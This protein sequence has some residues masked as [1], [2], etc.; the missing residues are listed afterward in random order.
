MAL[1]E[2]GSQVT[3]L[4]SIK[5]CFLF[6][7][8]HQCTFFQG[9]GECP[10]NFSSK[11]KMS[12]LQFPHYQSDNGILIRQLDRHSH[13]FFF[14]FFFGDRVSLYSPGDIPIL[15]SCL[16]LSGMFLKYC[17][18]FSM[19]IILQYFSP[20]EMTYDS[21]GAIPQCLSLN[22]VIYISIL[23]ILHRSVYSA[24]HALQPVRHVLYCYND[25]DYRTNL[26]IS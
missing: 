18:I 21:Q 14:F 26:K 22:T 16:K 20:K 25:R 23:I 19:K 8:L 10:E 15:K 11:R 9:S 24:G 6:L 4:F 2:L 5:F 12:V 13:S 1:Q 3:T 17:L 7:S